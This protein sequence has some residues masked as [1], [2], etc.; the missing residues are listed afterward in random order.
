MTD[1][2]NHL[3]AKLP[4]GELHTPAEN[5]RNVHLAVIPAAT[6]PKDIL[7]PIYWSHHARIFHTFDVIE[8]V[9]A[10]GSREVLLRVLFANSVEAHV[11]PMGAVVKHG[12]DSVNSNDPYEVA[13]AGP[14]AKW[15]VTRRTDKSVIKDGFATKE[16][17]D[18]YRREHQKVVPA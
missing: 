1:T 5:R 14:S 16:M 3:R 18:D 11:S 17:A 4:V 2:P 15:R 13:W 9:W 6:D 8:C 10:D 12:R 7:T